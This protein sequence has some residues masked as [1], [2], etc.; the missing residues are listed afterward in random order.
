[1]K[2][3]YHSMLAPA[4]EAT[5]TAVVLRRLGAVGAVTDGSSDIAGDLSGQTSV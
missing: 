2:K 1:M 3:S 5:A 4:Q